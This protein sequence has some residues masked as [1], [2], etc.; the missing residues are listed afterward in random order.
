[1][2]GG[3]DACI[4]FKKT[5]RQAKE[6]ELFTFVMLS[7]LG[8]K[9]HALVPFLETNF[10]KNL[11]NEQSRD[12]LCISTWVKL[13]QQAAELWGSHQSYSRGSGL[14]LTQG[15]VTFPVPISLQGPWRTFLVAKVPP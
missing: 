10:S 4:G 6:A 7:N 13:A 2:I 14:R 12:A 15:Q 9:W 8:T 1:M 5:H 3:D 11:E